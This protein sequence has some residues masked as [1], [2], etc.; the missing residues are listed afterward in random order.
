[1]NQFSTPVF[2]RFRGTNVLTLLMLVALALSVMGCDGGVGEVAVVDGVASEATA[3]AATDILADT[4]AD[5]VTE[6]AIAG[7]TDI[8]LDLGGDISTVEPFS[9]ASEA[10]GSS[11]ELVAGLSATDDDDGTTVTELDDKATGDL[12]LVALTARSVFLAE[13]AFLD[14]QH[15]RLILKAVEKK[16]DAPTWGSFQLGKKVVSDLEQTKRLKF[17]GADG[18]PKV[19]E[20]LR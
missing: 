3:A 4:A 6:T 20:S 15:K 8:A 17:T 2:L 12:R 19:F 1:M 5:A 18:N 13:A 10:D 9:A 16:G 14:V 11:E 7:S